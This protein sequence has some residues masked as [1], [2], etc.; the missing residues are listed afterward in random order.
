VLRP[1]RQR[2]VFVVPDA[3]IAGEKNGPFNPVAKQF[4]LI[5]TSFDPL[6][7][8]LALTELIPDMVVIS[9]NAQQWHNV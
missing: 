7:F 1:I 4:S 5:A 3:V 2:A 6:A 8:A 9:S